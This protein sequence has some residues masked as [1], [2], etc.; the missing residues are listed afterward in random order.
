MVLLTT[1][2]MIVVLTM[3][4]LTLMQAVCLY[5]K[6]NHSV[7]NNHE[8]LYQLETVARTLAMSQ[9]VAPFTDCLFTETNH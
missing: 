1:I 9:Q 8:S 4:V 5:I 7:V 6:I 2:M 3:L